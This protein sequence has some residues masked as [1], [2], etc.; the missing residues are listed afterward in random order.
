MMD[1]QRLEN[2]ELNREQ[3]D[4]VDYSAPDEGQPVAETPAQPKGP[5]WISRLK[6]FFNTRAT[7]QAGDGL[8]PPEADAP[9]EESEIVDQN[10]RFVDQEPSA[11]GENTDSSDQQNE[12]RPEKTTMAGQI[13]KDIKEFFERLISRRQNQEAGHD[14]PEEPGC[15]EEGLYEKARSPE[16]EIQPA[17]LEPE[18]PA[19]AAAETKAAPAPEPE[20][21]SDEVVP[22]EGREAVGIQ[23]PERAQVTGSVVT[24]WVKKLFSREPDLP[25]DEALALKLSQKKALDEEIKLR[26]KQ[27]AHTLKK[28]NRSKKERKQLLDYQVKIK[29]ELTQILAIMKDRSRDVSGLEKQSL[30][31][32]REIEE[33]SGRHGQLL[34]QIQADKSRLESVITVIGQH[35]AESEIVDGELAAKQNSLSSLVSQLEQSKAELD[36]TRVETSFL[37]REKDATEQTLNDFKEQI[38]RLEQE[39]T[40]KNRQLEALLQQLE[41]KQK[42]TEE[43]LRQSMVLEG[44]LEGL[45]QDLRT[46]QEALQSDKDQVTGLEAGIK[47]GQ[48]RQEILNSQL[49]QLQ[50]QATQQQQALF[51]LK[52]ETENLSQTRAGIEEQLRQKQEE[53]TGAESLLVERNRQVASLEKGIEELQQSTANRQNVQQLLQQ[54]IDGLKSDGLA[55]AKRIDE[56]SRQKQSMEAGLDQAWK[57]LSETETMISQRENSRL[58]TEGTLQKLQADVMGAL[59]QTESLKQEMLQLE[60]SRDISSQKLDEISQSLAAVQQNQQKTS[61]DLERTRQSLIQAQEEYDKLGEERSALQNEVKQKKADNAALEDKYQ[62]LQS[63]VNES[64]AR[65][66]QAG[67]EQQKLRVQ[68]TALE[69]ERQRLKDE[70]KLLNQSGRELNQAR[71]MLQSQKQEVEQWVKEAVPFQKQQQSQIEQQLERLKE[72]QQQASGVKQQMEGDRRELEEIDRQNQELMQ[73]RA[74]GVMTA[75][76]E[77][78]SLHQQIGEKNG[79]LNVLTEKITSCQSKKQQMEEEGGR[80]Q[81]VLEALRNSHDQAQSDL[82]EVQK[83]LEQARQEMEQRLK[84]QNDELLQM[85]QDTEAAKNQVKQ[86]LTSVQGQLDDKYRQ[87]DEANEMVRQTEDELSAKQRQRDEIDLQLINLKNDQKET[88]SF[89]EDWDKKM[90]GL[91][92]EL[93]EKQKSVS[94]KSEEESAILKRLKMLSTEAAEYQA[95]SKELNQLTRK[96][97]DQKRV[98]EDLDLQAEKKSGLF[99]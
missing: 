39:Q 72:L 64:I 43:K 76:S 29:S 56:M 96:I 71:E 77:L 81:A 25:I 60:G 92:Q 91:N 45:R 84:N 87:L 47:D 11:A 51:L 79:E 62:E 12:I 8:L 3:T 83:S 48:I 44:V 37:H 80:T 38:I 86:Q 74:R 75:E 2:E 36:S 53:L 41:L 19:T 21:A 1:E 35:K 57:K 6:D 54:K 55:V 34:D 52:N 94:Q 20:Y 24:G 49:E 16:Q 65:L 66:E 28:L 10:H 82:L 27:T 89:K 68:V 7:G 90:A 50:N 63:R 61:E 13:K 93:D 17:S 95:R 88:L 30:A 22:P 32:Q 59:A 46:S 70:I 42:E 99:T 78:A 85:A 33:S 73:E 69:N 5:G 18:P 58:E 31:L 23:L 15:S 26:R 9:P 14:L 98:L 97:E 40:E 4:A 67:G